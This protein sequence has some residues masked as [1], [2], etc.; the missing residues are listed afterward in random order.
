MKFEWKYKSFLFK[1]CF[2][3]C[4]Q[5]AATV[6]GICMLTV[7]IN[8][9]FD[10]WLTAVLCKYLSDWAGI[11]LC[12]RPANERPHYIVMSSLIG[13]VH[14]QNSPWLSNS[15]HNPIPW[16]PGPVFYAEIILCMHPANEKWRYSVTP[17]LIG[18]EHT[19]NDLYWCMAGQGLGQGSKA[20]HM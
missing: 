15:K 20:L 13:R 7:Y 4:L 18:W 8:L 9:I 16:R 17:S 2:W 14:T 11:I 6:S 3:K 5:T 12:M 19:Q 1:T 10:C